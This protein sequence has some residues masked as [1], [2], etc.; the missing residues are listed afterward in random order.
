MQ[1]SVNAYSERF[2]FLDAVAVHGAFTPEDAS[3]QL[4]TSSC[5]DSQSSSPEPEPLSFS[6]SAEF[7]K[8]F[9]F[10]VTSKRFSLVDLAL[11]LTAVQQEHADHRWTDSYADRSLIEF[12]SAEVFAF[13][14]YFL[15]LD[16]RKQVLEYRRS[17][18]KRFYDKRV[19]AW[20]TVSPHRSILSLEPCP[21]T[22]LK[23]TQ[24]LSSPSNKL[25][26]DS[27]GLLSSPYFS[28]QL[29]GADDEQSQT[30]DLDHERRLLSCMK[31][32]V[33]F[34][35]DELRL[36]WMSLAAQ[37]CALRASMMYLDEEEC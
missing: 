14:D 7:I 13:L 8:H 20:N 22:L 35:N 26:D 5:S 2:V 29:V 34:V 18:A 1:V 37:K 19:V 23:R 36:L 21:L 15:E 31:D 17:I 3:D 27:G 4:S 12:T 32:R 30:Q 6:P 10:P 24:W 11:L 33:S 16:W 25:M 28:S 9:Q